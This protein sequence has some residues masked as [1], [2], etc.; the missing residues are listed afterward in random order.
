MSRVFDVFSAGTLTGHST[1]NDWPCYGERRTI[2]ACVVTAD[3][4]RALITAP[5]V[6]NTAARR[7]IFIDLRTL[8]HRAAQSHHQ[9]LWP[10][11]GA[12]IASAL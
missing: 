11:A 5:A 12:P 9:C 10:L 4:K 8:L 3:R 7:L 6:L 2:L 1:A